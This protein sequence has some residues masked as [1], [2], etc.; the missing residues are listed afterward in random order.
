MK[1]IYKDGIVHFKSMLKTLVINPDRCT[2]C[3]ICELACSYKHFKVN[4]PEKSRIR[5]VR[6]PHEPVDSPI[7]CIQCGL[8]ID[9]CPFGAISRNLKTSA[10]KVDFEKCTGCGI[11]VHVCPYGA[12][13]RDP[14]T[15]KALI[16]D[17]CD[18]DP[19][20]A[21]LC[22]EGVLLYLD[23]DKAAKYKRITF[24]KLQ[25]RETTPLKPDVR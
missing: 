24:S 10:I 22:P 18:G 5:V 9:A 8:C 7:Y 16:C 23:P 11:C 19:E 13:A 3:R 21:K 12:A 6:L 20:C 2:G 4:N 1:K 14:E 17:L 15:N 25:R